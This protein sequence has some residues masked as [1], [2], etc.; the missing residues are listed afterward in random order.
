MPRACHIPHTHSLCHRPCPYPRGKKKHLQVFKH[1][2]I[3]TRLKEKYFKE[4]KARFGGNTVDSD[5]NTGTAIQVKKFA[6]GW[7]MFYNF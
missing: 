1:S 7:F 2:N 3:F 4:K 6:F 5:E